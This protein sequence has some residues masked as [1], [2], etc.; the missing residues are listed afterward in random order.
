MTLRTNCLSTGGIVKRSAGERG[1][2]SKGRKG[3]THG[4]ARKEKDR[5]RRQTNCQKKQ[6]TPALRQSSIK[7]KTIHEGEV[8][9]TKLHALDWRERLGVGNRGKVKKGKKYRKKTAIPERIILLPRLNKAS[10]A[11]K[12][13]RRRVTGLH[14]LNEKKKI[15][16]LEGGHGVQIQNRKNR[17]LFFLKTTARHF[18]TTEE[19]TTSSPQKQLAANS[20]RKGINRGKSYTH[21]EFEDHEPDHSRWTLKKSDRVTA[22]VREGR[23]EI[24]RP[25]P[26]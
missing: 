6:L 22:N 11:K 26:A 2:N 14:Q 20:L 16:N 24:R 4:A 17:G 1:K 25:A 5:S 18:C 19:S 3:C 7:G 23:K 8:L 12:L 10:V 9:R 21:A 13:S 15:V